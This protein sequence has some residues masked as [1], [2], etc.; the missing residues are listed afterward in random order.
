[1]SRNLQLYFEDIL[2]SI[3]KIER[4][5]KDLSYQQF[6]ADEKT[7]DAVAYNLQIIGEA[8]KRRQRAEGQLKMFLLK[9]VKII[10]K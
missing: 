2:N 3:G 4:Y 10:L 8:I 7:F 6:I 5:I 1:M 9:F